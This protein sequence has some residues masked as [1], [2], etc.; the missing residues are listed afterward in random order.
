MKPC[1][2]VRYRALPFSLGGGAFSS[3]IN[4]LLA[5]GF[6]LLE[7]RFSVIAFFRSQLRHVFS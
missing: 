6:S 7:S 1:N 5:T 3:D 2:S 4:A